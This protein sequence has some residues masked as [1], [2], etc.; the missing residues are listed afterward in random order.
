MSAKPSESPSVTVSAQP[1]SQPSE[2]PSQPTS[3]DVQVI[4]NALQETEFASFTVSVEG[5]TTITAQQEISCDE[6]ED[7][8]EGVVKEALQETNC[9]NIVSGCEVEILSIDCGTRRRR[10][11]KSRGLVAGI[12]NL[13]VQFIVIVKAYCSDKQCSNGKDVADAIYESVTTTFEESIADDTF[14]SVSQTFMELY[15]SYLSSHQHQL[16]VFGIFCRL[17]L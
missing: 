3:A 5:E 12:T 4:S 6:D 9:A 8:L 16:V 1:I 7:Y 2:T 14:V 10:E 11:L 13:V 15:I 17:M